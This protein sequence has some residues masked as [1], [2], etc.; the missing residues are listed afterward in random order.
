MEVIIVNDQAHVNGGAPAVAFASARGL[1]KRG[2]PVTLFTAVGP[3]APELRAEVDLEVH[4]LEQREIADDPNRLRAFL[5]GMRNGPAVAAMHRLLSTRDPRHTIIHVHS[6]TKALSPFVIS[7]AIE[8]GFK[9][10]VTLHD[11]FI[12][13]PTGGFFV[14]KDNAICT[15]TPLSA[16]CLSC[17]CDRRNYAH[18]LWRSGRTFLQNQMLGIPRGVAHFVGVSQFSIDIMRGYLPMDARITVVRN[19]ID[20]PPVDPAPIATNAPL[21]YIGRFSKEKGPLLLAEAVRRTGAPAV[22]I[23]D[24]EVLAQAKTICPEA[25]FTGWLPAEEVRGWLSKARALVFPPL[26]YE[27]LGLVVV[28]A[29]AHGVPAIV[30]SRCA[31]VDYIRH[32]ETGLHFEHGS[33][34]SLCEQIERLKDDELATRLGRNAYEWFWN[35]PWTIDSHVTELMHVYEELLRAPAPAM[36]PAA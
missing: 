10:V 19:P 22:F 33:V 5:T 12:T 18:K 26:W 30:A 16:D 17:S 29:A 8:R 7:A 15:R 25:T 14:H 23:G 28:E 32:G 31:A 2:I 21:L 1:L 6:W 24:G 11:F 3:V 4:C 20:C 13:C 9:V 27:T 36:S 34:D 35:D